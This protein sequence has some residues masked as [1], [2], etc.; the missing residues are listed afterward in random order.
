[1]VSRIYLCKEMRRETGWGSVEEA[2][3]TCLSLLSQS[4]ATGS[5]LCDSFLFFSVDILIS[6]LSFFVF[7]MDLICTLELLDGYGFASLEWLLM[8]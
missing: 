2:W 5:P 3:P 1:M 7:L 6:F 8:N 4:L